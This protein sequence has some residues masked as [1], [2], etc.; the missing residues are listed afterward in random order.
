MIKPIKLLALLLFLSIF[1]FVLSCGGGGGGGDSSEGNNATITGTVAGT[2]IVAIDENNNEVARVSAT[3]AGSPKSFTLIVPVGSKYRLYFIENEGTANEKVFF[4]YQDTTN[5]FNISSAVTIDLGFVDTSSGVAVPANNPL[6][7]SGVTSGGQ[8]T[9]LPQG[10]NDNL[11][12]SIPTGLSAT[13]VSSSQIDLSWTASKDNVGVSG[14]KIYRDGT[15]LKSITTTSTSDTGISPS[16]QYCYTI[17]AYD[18]A[19]NESAQSSEA[20][21][22]TTL[23]SWA[24]TY[25][26]AAGEEATSIQQTSDGGYIVTGGTKSFGAGDDDIWVLKL[27]S[28]GNVQWQKTYGGNNDDESSSIQQTSDGGYIVAGGTKCFG[29]G[30]DDIWVLK[31]D[32]SGN[33]Q[34]QKTYGGSADDEGG[35][36]Q[37]TSD[38]GYIVA[39]ST[40]SFGAGGR[41]LWVLKLDSNGNVLW[42]KT[43]GGEMKDEAHSIQQ[44]SDGG[45]IVAGATES[46]GA[47]EG[48]LVLKLDSSGNVQWQKRGC[49]NGGKATSIRQTLDG[50]YIVAS[51]GK[52]SNEEDDFWVL[53]LDSSGNVLWQKTYGGA[54]DEEPTSIQQTS[55]GGYIVTGENSSF[56]AG[57]GDFWVLKLD[58]S[59]NVQWQKAY[60]GANGELSGYI[61]QTSDGGYIVAGAT[62]SFGAGGA[63]VW[64]LKL[65]PDGSIVFNPSSGATTA[66]TS[67]VV[68]NPSVILENT[69][70]TITNTT[71]TP[72]NT[73][74]TVTNTNATIVQQAP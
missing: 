40:K 21:A 26:G 20:C 70:A 19:G 17:S 73:S 54:G 51:P 44:T 42:Q 58:S 72:A 57:G 68:T 6:D 41:D 16:P 56:G 29:A 53:K 7:V 3:G 5:V 8:D 61:Q 31:L 34:W 43:Y 27:D 37:Q 36:I 14:Y 2:V 33:V 38:G 23:T 13:A 4:L 39:V 59:G 30:D 69:T 50:G 67:A 55:D 74:A 48:F 11:T 22:T 46:F 45:Y 66:N 64:I 47:G 10:V 25:G 35:D 9:S 52:P 65:N 62:E 49:L 15:Y 60:G 1:P 63:D 24:K 12:P 18:A 71:V 32:S 28:S